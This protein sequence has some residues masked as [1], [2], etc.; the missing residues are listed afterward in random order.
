MRWC[1]LFCLHS[2]HT[3]AATLA[4]QM[5]D[6]IVHADILGTITKNIEALKEQIK[7]G[8]RGNKRV[9]QE[10]KETMSLAVVELLSNCKELEEQVGSIAGFG[11]KHWRGLTPNPNESPDP[12][13][14]PGLLLTGCLH[15][16]LR[17]PVDE[18]KAL[19]FWETKVLKDLGTCGQHSATESAQCQNSS[20]CNAGAYFH[21][22]GELLTSSSLYSTSVKDTFQVTSDT[23]VAESGVL[24]QPINPHDAHHH[25]KDRL[26]DQT[27][28]MLCR[29]MDMLCS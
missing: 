6:K 26:T 19:Q 22:A 17:V 23:L 8:K 3:A 5:Q 27:D 25:T 1:V 18:A 24:V 29:L 14:S 12:N 9:I 20:C 10:Q 15:Q 11:S 13:E 7:K 16:I 4:V 2:G 21:E 28:H